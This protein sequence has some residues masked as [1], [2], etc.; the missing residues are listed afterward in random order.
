[1]PSRNAILLV[2]SVALA[3]SVVPF[4]SPAAADSV[5]RFDASPAVVR[6]SGGILEWEAD[7][8]CPGPVATQGARLLFGFDRNLDGAPDAVD[9]LPL[10]AG[11]CLDGLLRV[12]RTFPPPFPSVLRT[13]IRDARGNTGGS[14]GVLT[15]G[16]GSLLSI[17][18]YCA[19]PRDGE[20]EWVEILNV[21]QVPVSLQHARLQRRSL[22]GAGL[23]EPGESLTVGRDT[24]NLR[25][26]R[27][28]GRLFGTGTWS[29]LRNA[30]DTLR[31]SLD[32]GLSLDSLAYGAGGFPL[33]ACASLDVDGGGG[34]A[35]AAFGYSIE[36]GAPRWRRGSPPIRVEVRAPETGRYDLRAYDLD[37]LELC[38]LARGASGNTSHA[39]PAPG[40][41]HQ[42]AVGTV[43][44]VLHPRDAPAVRAVLRIT[45]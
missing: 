16:G 38:V 17:H 3:A 19:R 5:P 4:A 30:G 42:R 39:F 26:W 18:R 1:M 36:T 22:A 9:T 28:V 32:D 20:P 10:A 27:P 15:A 35:G 34:S 29:N 31:L 45:E 37:G 7:L 41:P 33:E 6:H 14:H 23:L 43:L 11:D 8:R 13:E 24:A 25:A 44:F 2:A 12:R 40:C 21:S